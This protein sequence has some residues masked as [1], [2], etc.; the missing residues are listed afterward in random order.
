MSFKKDREKFMNY[1]IVAK[2]LFK[3]QISHVNLDRVE[4]IERATS[5]AKKVL[6]KIYPTRDFHELYEEQ[7]YTIVINSFT[8]DKM[9]EEEKFYTIGHELYHIPRGGND[10]ASK[11]FRKT[12]PHDKE[13][14]LWLVKKCGVEMEKMKEIMENAGKEESVKTE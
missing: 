1:A 4:F 2:D 5:R 7:D 3:E 6:A 12:V 14:F 10:P 9:N 11:K 13:D 8:W